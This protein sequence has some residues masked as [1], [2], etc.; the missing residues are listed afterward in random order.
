MLRE[1][2]DLALEEAAGDTRAS[3]QLA[4]RVLATL[5]GERPKA[6]RGTELELRLQHLH[7]IVRAPAA[8]P[9]R[10]RG[11]LHTSSLLVNAAGESLLEHLRSEFE[12]ADR[13]DLLCLAPELFTEAP[14]L[15][16]R[17]ARD[18]SGAP[19]PCLWL[20]AAPADAPGLDDAA[21]VLAKPLDAPRVAEACL[22]LCAQ[23]RQPV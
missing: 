3:V 2:L 4:E 8:P 21:V 14:E 12:S 10:P 15:L 7:S 1:A 19:R 22:G 23:H 16:E 5:A 13:V 17:L 18:E 9:R 20:G 6:F 11:S